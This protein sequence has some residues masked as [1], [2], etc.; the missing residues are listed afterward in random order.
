MSPLSRG[1]LDPQLAGVI[2]AWRPCG[3]SAA[4]AGFAREVV[5]RAGPQRVERVRALLFAASRLAAFGERVGLELRSEVLLSEAAIERFILCGTQGFSPATAR[6]LR[7]NLRALS[8]ALDAH[9][10]PL[11]T[12]LPRERAKAPYRQAEIDGYL[13]LA[14]AQSTLS[15]RM[16]CQALICL[17]TG[18]GVVAG[19][20]RC[21]RGSDVV[22]RSGGVIVTVRGA[23]ARSVPVL[24][25]Y[26]GPL[27]KAARFAGEGLI[28]GGRDPHRRNVSDALCRALCADPCLPRL[29][30]GRLRSTWLHEAA[31]AIG[32]QAFMAAAGVSCSQRL[33]DITAVLPRASETEIVAL[34][35]GPS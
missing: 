19:E 6:T 30:A 21:I 25:R 31:K 13:R 16:R 26:Q 2:A 5:G 3:T 12:P 18:A 7:T 24:L 4:A 9:P 1:E 35:Q 32:L 34:L 23:R 10:Q 27:A 15:R 11:P 33:G 28:I 22:V 29:Q 8:R 20:L 14:E 17:G